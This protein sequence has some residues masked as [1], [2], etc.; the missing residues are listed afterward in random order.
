MK[1]LPNIANTDSF[2][3]PYFISLLQL[4]ESFSAAADSRIQQTKRAFTKKKIV[5]V[6]GLVPPSFE[7]LCV[8][9]QS[10][11]VIQERDKACLEI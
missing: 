7:N 5:G 3:E 10:L 9:R 8:V 2:K 1:L 4:K 6:G 11:F